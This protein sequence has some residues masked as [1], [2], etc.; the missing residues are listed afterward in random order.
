VIAK[1]L[2]AR[3]Y[4]R[5]HF[6]MGK[7]GPVRRKKLGPFPVTT[8]TPINGACGVEGCGRPLK[9]KGMC[10]LHYGRAYHYGAVGDS[11]PT[12]RH[13]TR[14]PCSVEGCTKEARAHGLCGT[15]NRRRMVSGDPGPAELL[16]AAKG[17]GTTTLDGYRKITVDGKSVFEHRHVL[18]QKLGRPLLPGENAHHIDGNRA[19]NDPSNIELWVVQQPAGQR[20]TDLV[21]AAIKLLRQYPDLVADEGVRLINLESQEST[22]VLI[23]WLAEEDFWHSDVGRQ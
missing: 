14:V 1:G 20:A 12:P 5:A 19:R 3:C 2:C 17:E 16:V 6:G 9:Q 22:D 13:P 4:Q 7:N 23:Q 18:E 21:K 15:H 11:K 10:T 8:L